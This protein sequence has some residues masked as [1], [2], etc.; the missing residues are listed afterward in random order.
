M[1]LSLDFKIKNHEKNSDHQSNSAIWLI[2]M[3]K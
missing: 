2:G 1:K 3:W